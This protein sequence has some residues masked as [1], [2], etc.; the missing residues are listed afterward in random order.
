MEI[1]RVCKGCA[2]PLG[3][4]HHNRRWHEEC[5]RLDY[6]AKANARLKAK[7]RAA[8]ANRECAD[9]GTGIGHR[10][11]L[12]KYCQ[13]CS[14]VR[15][16]A[17]AKEWHARKRK[18]RKPCAQC[19]GSTAGRAA[20]AQF[21]QECARLRKR[22]RVNLH[23]INRRSQGQGGPTREALFRA[24]I[25]ARD[26]F[27]CHICGFP[28]SLRYSPSDPLSPVVDHLIPLALPET[29]GHVWE[30][31]AC[32]HKRCNNK[33]H[34]KVTQADRRLYLRLCRMRE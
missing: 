5:L 27:V 33:K 3:Q 15:D 13:A 1:L 31:A 4:V 7:R 30:N 26:E 20:R 29:P 9:C 14:I 21:C 19:G 23:R 16:Q 25:F 6:K 24:E 11:A 2:Q 17:A 8:R 34:V 32:A 18:P 10:S 12:A 22:D 28:T